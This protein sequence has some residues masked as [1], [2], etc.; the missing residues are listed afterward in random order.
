ML[1]RVPVK[2][3]RDKCKS[4]YVKDTKCAICGTTSD[5]EF[6]HYYSISELLQKYIKQ[7]R[8]NIDDVLEYRDDFIAKH[9]AELFDLTVTLCSS[10]HS[11]LHKIYGVSPK[12]VTAKKQM[13]WIERVKNV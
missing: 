10:C 3:I 6:H 13:R 1:K 2:Y 11:R 5:L 9:Q 7:N 4:Q 8:L 12:L